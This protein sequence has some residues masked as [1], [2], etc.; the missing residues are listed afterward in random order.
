M[1][2]EYSIAC[3]EVLEVLKYLPQ[4][5]KEKIPVAEIEFYEENKAEDYAFKYDINKPIEEQGLSKLTNAIIITIYRDYFAND[6]QRFLLSEILKENVN[7]VENQR[8]EKYGDKDKNIKAGN[9]NTEVP[10]PAVIKKKKSGF[11]KILDF[12]KGIFKKS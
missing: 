4:E 11:Q 5:E 10:K 6:E 9:S 7:K 2:R 3:T 12:I 1:T 8:R